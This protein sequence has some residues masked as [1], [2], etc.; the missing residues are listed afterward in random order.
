MSSLRNTFESTTLCPAGSFV[1]TFTDFRNNHSVTTQ[2]RDLVNAPNSTEFRNTLQSK[3]I[4]LV[5]STQ[6]KLVCQ[7]VSSDSGSVQYN[8]EIKLNYAQNNTLAT[9]FKPLL[10]Q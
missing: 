6:P 1:G 4:E 10:E 9:A 5:E 7:P 3:G 8:K 2:L